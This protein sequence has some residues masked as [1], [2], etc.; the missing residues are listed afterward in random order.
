M[1]S[2]TGTPG[3]V[4]RLAWIDWLKVIVV[5][6]VFAYHA[7]QPF[8][9]TSWI[10]VAEEKSLLLSALAGLGY[11]FGMPLMFLLAG[12]ASWAALQGTTV[13]A[14]ARKRLRLVL[15][16]V[17]GFAILSPL[18]AWI[19]A[20]TR[21]ESIG[22]LHFAVRYWTD[23]ELPLGPTWFGDYGYHLWFIAFLLVYALVSLPLLVRLR[24]QPP[25]RPTAAWMV[26]LP[27][28]GLIIGQVPLRVA[29]P[30]YRDWA[31]FAM[32]LAYFLAGAALLARPAVLQSIAGRGLVMVV[33]GILLAAAMIPLFQDGS[34]MTLESSPTFDAA[35]LGY[36][37]V[38]TVI[39]ACWVVVAVA[40]G[41]RWFD[42]RGAQA[43]EASRLVLPFYV[44]HHPIVVV[45]AAVVV[46]LS[47]PMGLSFVT[48]LAVAGLLTLGACL[49]AARQSALRVLFGM[50]A[51]PP[52]P[53]STTVPT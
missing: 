52:A 38:R 11:L 17:A 13:V 36:I 29:F 48:I 45:V 42:G 37:V 2:A 24:A 19:G 43:R 27:I 47:L 10:V 25:L 1:S 16:L 21:G 33:P 26:T 3:D 22:P 40:I 6:G 53:R 18:Q 28:A 9:L 39:G 51:P 5:L 30:A 50:G 4:R 34:G 35:S 14:Y 31:D 23:A 7:A 20:S 44:L 15:P 46:P 8:V 49:A 12:A 32:W 41:S